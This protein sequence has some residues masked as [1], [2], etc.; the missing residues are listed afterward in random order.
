MKKYLKPLALTL[1]ILL[2]LV[3]FPLSAIAKTLT[4]TVQT[5]NL[6]DLGTEKM[7]L[8]FAIDSLADDTNHAPNSQYTYTPGTYTHQGS[9]V[10]GD[11]GTISTGTL[12][13]KTW[14]GYAG[15]TDIPLDEN[16]QYTITFKM[17]VLSTS[18]HVLF[19]L[20]NPGEKDGKTAN[21]TTQAIAIEGASLYLGKGMAW[22]N[23]SSP[24]TSV[25]KIDSAEHEYVI[26]INGKLITLFRDG[27][28]WGVLDAAETTADSTNS[29]WWSASSFW[30]DSVLGFGYRTR[31][32]TTSSAKDMAKL[33]DIKVYQG[34][35]EQ[36]TVV[37]NNYSDN[38]MLFSVGHLNSTDLTTEFTD[39]SVT[40]F[41]T[42]NTEFFE[43]DPTAFRLNDEMAALAETQPDGLVWTMYGLSTNLPLTAE[44]RYTVEFYV[45]NPNSVN[46]ALCWAGTQ[47]NNM[48]GIY[49]YPNSV[50][51]I[52]GYSPKAYNTENP[53]FSKVFTGH[54][55]KDGF[56]RLVVEI[57]GKK[58]T[59]YI[60]GVKAA[61]FDFG[62]GNWNSENLILT[63]KAHPAYSN[64]ANPIA[65][66]KD[67]TVY[68][69][70]VEQNCHINFFNGD[71]QL[72]SLLKRPGDVIEAFPEV[73][74]PEGKL[75]VWFHRGKNIVVQAPYTVVSDV[76]LEV[77]FLNL[78]DIVIA[79]VQS[80]TPTA[81]GTQSVRFIGALQTL[82]ASAVGFEITATYLE[83][84]VLKTK[85]WNRE[86]GTVYTSVMATV[87]GETT[88]VSANE[89]GGSYVVAIAVEN[90]PVGI[91]QIDFTIRAY[92]TVD[93]VKAYSEAMTV[94]FVNG[95]Y[96]AEAAPLTGN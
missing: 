92:L 70:N 7:P 71:S 6:K 80:T 49:F 12:K 14:Q 67:V 47:S 18:T 31:I 15:R 16:S 32:A 5:D 78:S 46:L 19:T 79:A 23:T 54:T 43:D 96:S 69:G 84:G 4:T 65:W 25:E 10:C 75:A 34:A 93:G 52:R 64:A 88:K 66:V 24:V 22:A 50:S 13:S 33:T 37:T 3:A 59:A 63:L 60:A 48:Q 73:T 86:T 30:S 27:S 45:K 40:K 28:L 9:E 95:E 87:D 51:T 85:S 17:Q 39:L 1:S 26:S 56:T 55:N 81:G 44:S 82:Q 35:V 42:Q 90:V 2:L 72:Q 53:G 89:L 62:E 94:S 41:A 74:A 83:D 29:P 8:I 36:T 68:A 57:N 58:A 21:N 91:G 77:R 61:E 76:D 20:T 11:D 38:D